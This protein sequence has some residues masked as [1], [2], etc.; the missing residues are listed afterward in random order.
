MA[1]LQRLLQSN[2]VFRFE[3]MKTFLSGLQQTSIAT[4]SPSNLNETTGLLPQNANV[5]LPRMSPSYNVNLNTTNLN[6]SSTITIDNQGHANINT[7]VTASVSNVPNPLEI[8]EETSESEKVLLKQ[9]TDTIVGAH[10]DTTINTHANV[11]D[12]NTR[13]KESN[14]QSDSNNPSLVWKQFAAS[15]VPELTKV[16]NF[17][18]MLPGFSEVNPEDQVQLI[19]QGSFEV[20]VTRISLLIDE[21]SQEMLDPQLKMK[22]KR[23]VV[24]QMP[25]GPLIDQMFQIAEQLNPL[26]LTDG[27]YGL[28]T[29]ALFISPD[30]TGLQNASLIKTIQQ[31]YMRALYQLL[32]QTH[33]DPDKTFRNLL[34]IL[35]LLNQINQSHIKFL[36]NIKDKSPEM[37]SAHFP[38]LHQE[39]FVS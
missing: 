24:R 20:M 11:L 4:T 23:E 19:K 10:L 6:T 25:M 21:V 37:F 31:L 17:C 29:A 35:P 28:F 18:K 3:P 7:N 12:A 27:E 13:I 39:V 2:E 14:K 9:I 33:N 5:N 15:M 8:R 22:C 16:I 36:N 38:Q 1:E 26:R 34:S 32:K 30:R